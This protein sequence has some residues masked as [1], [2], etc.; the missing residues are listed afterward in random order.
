MLRNRIRART[1]A[2]GLIGIVLLIL[3]G[4]P[5]L[6]QNGDANDIPDDTINA[7]GDSALGVPDEDTQRIVSTIESAAVTLDAASALPSTDALTQLAAELA[8]DPSV[9][10]AEPTSQGISI[11][12][13]NGMRLMLIT[14]WNDEDPDSPDEDPPEIDPKPGAPKTFDLRAA[15][16]APTSARTILYNP[17]YWQ[18]KKYTPKIIEYGN[19]AFA[20][21]GMSAFEVFRGEECTLALLRNLSDYGVIHFYSHGYAW[22]SGTNRQE[23]YLMTG[24]TGSEALVRDRLPEELGER[25]RMMLDGRIAAAF[26]KF[27]FLDE[28]E[29]VRRWVFLASPQYI[30]DR[31]DLAAKRPLVYQGFCWS[32]LGTWSQKLTAEGVGANLG[33]DWWVKT[34]ESV[35]W[36]MLMYRDLGDH[37]RID[38]LTLGAWY[39]ALGYRTYHIVDKHFGNVERDV[40]LMKGGQDA[41]TLW[42]STPTRVLG[43]L[44]V[45]D[46]IRDLT[47]INDL[48]LTVDQNTGL[49]AY[50]IHTPQSIGRLGGISLSMHSSGRGITVV[51]QTAY[52]SCGSFRMVDV[53]NPLDM[54]LLEG[55]GLNSD[56]NSSAVLGGFAFVAAGDLSYSQDDG[57]FGIVDVT[58][59]TVDKSRNVGGLGLGRYLSDVALFADGKTVCV[60]DSGGPIYFIDVQD[61][62][63]PRL[64]SQLTPSKGAY[65]NGTGKVRI[66][67]STVYALTTGLAIIDAS[68]RSAP[69][70]LWSVGN[71]AGT[72]IAFSDNRLY[73]AGSASGGGGGLLGAWDI[74]DPRNPVGIQP[75]IPLPGYPL[76]IEIVGTRAYVG[77]STLDGKGILSVVDV[78]P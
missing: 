61:P 26:T 47:I 74:T 10:F 4:C 37:G 58:E 62:R 55:S 70:E 1:C 41:L 28:T 44:A 22:P 33:F 24:Q 21:C 8:A 77:Q 2:L 25:R 49:A 73:V 38:P 16:M 52:V 19:A 56:C 60:A 65:S 34:R 15:G 35:R 69:V 40:T 17:H 64:L 7:N 30:V 50:D 63:N 54:K 71:S 53:S 45:D 29:P 68:N 11:Q 42:E 5:G 72:D 23:V 43:S 20:K 27:Q 75:N 76:C 13:R 12:S 57:V 66:V 67:G 48:A 6:N 14:D 18:R 46:R 32:F 39:N 51:G 31:N 36:S 59:P 78:T 3:G 9:E